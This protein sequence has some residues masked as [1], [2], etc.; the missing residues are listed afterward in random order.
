MFA[1]KYNA[2]K[3]KNNEGDFVVLEI[4]CGDYMLIIY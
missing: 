1:F 3:L 4:S 2:I